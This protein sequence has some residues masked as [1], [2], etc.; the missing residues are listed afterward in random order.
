MSPLALSNVLF[1]QT[2]QKILSLAY[3]H[4]ERSYFTN[5]IGR[6]VQMGK[7]TVMR[8]LDK[9]QACGIL[10]KTHQGNQTHYQ[11]NAD[12]PIYSEL[13]SIVRKT[14]GIDAEIRSALEP[15]ENEITWAFI[16]G[17][18]AKGTA[19]SDSDIDLM[20]I[21]DGLAYSDI[22]AKL[23]PVEQRVARVINPTIYTLSDWH[24]KIS[25]Q[26][27]FVTRVSEQDKIDLIGH[28]PGDNVA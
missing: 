26:N 9:L 16:F 1:T 3:G 14:L 27:S 17:S 4:P 2:Q 12:C 7:G 18:I 23:L 13:L 22:M 21:G 5:E 8:E 25:V 24:L 19:Q 20:I 15:L 11:A 10:R 6:W 28:D